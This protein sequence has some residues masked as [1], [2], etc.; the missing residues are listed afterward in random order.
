M[1]RVIMT[2]LRMFEELFVI[3]RIGPCI[4]ICSYAEQDGVSNTLTL[5]AVNL[6]NLGYL[7]TQ[8]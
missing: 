7:S 6:A 4:P 1:G 3:L 2:P 5:R 8:L